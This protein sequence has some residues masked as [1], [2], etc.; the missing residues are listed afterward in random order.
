MFDSRTLR[1]FLLFAVLLVLP[2]SACAFPWDTDMFKQQSFKA[3]ELSRA[4]VEGTVPLGN[5][6]F[7]MNAEEAAK[8]LQNPLAFNRDTVWRG[9]RLWKSNC[10]TCHG[11]T[12]LGDGPVGPAMETIPNLLDDLYKAREDGRIYAVIQL[13][14][15]NMPR[16]GYKFSPDEAWSLVHYV[17]FLQGKEVEGVARN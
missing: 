2:E 17:R 1:G 14:Q 5:R 15:G 9:R 10:Q 7:R 4:P 16:V 13:G 3:N 6:P 8:E 12:G 11:V